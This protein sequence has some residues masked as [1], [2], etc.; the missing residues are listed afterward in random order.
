MRRA[1]AAAASVLAALAVVGSATADRTVFKNWH[2]HSGLPGHRPASFFPALL[3]VSLADY[4]ADPALWAYCP[5]AADKMLLPNGMHGS[6]IAA[7]ACRNESTVIHLMT[8]SPKQP[9]PAGWARIPG[10]STA[11][12]RL[13]PRG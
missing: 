12:Y 13:T 7:G 4:Q 9:P 3:G 1:A 11:Y 5:D 10:T 2:I 6:K 8:V